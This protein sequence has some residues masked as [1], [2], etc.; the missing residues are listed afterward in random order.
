[1]SD[2]RFVVAGMALAFGALVAFGT[3]GVPYFEVVAQA[4]SFEE[5]HE[6][7]GGSLVDCDAALAGGS[8]AV[9]VPAALAGAAGYALIRGARGTW[10]QDVPDADM[11][12]PPRRG[13]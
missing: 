9:A 4:E 2:M 8:W 10:D 1:M 12:G 3:I 13:G 5:C 7:G 6:Y 11:A